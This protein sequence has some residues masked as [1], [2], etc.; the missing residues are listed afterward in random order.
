MP[1]FKRKTI[2]WIDFTEP[3]GKRVRRSSCTKVKAEAQR[4]HDELKARAW[5]VS[6]LGEKPRRTWDEA[7][8]KWLHET[9]DKKDHEGDKAKLRWLT[10]HL[11]GK[12]ID[13]IDR[14]VLMHL[15]ELKREET[16]ASTANRYTALLRA[17]LRR[18]HGRWQWLDKVPTMELFAEPAGRERW[19][20]AEQVERLLAELPDHQKLV[21]LFALAT[22]L[23]QGNILDLEWDRVDMRR[24]VCWIHGAQTKNRQALHVALNET[25]MG[26]LRQAAGEHPTR[27]FTYHGR[28]LS[29]ANTRAWRQALLR[30]GIENF[31]WHDLRHTW[32]SWMIQGGVPEFILQRMG[33]WKSAEMVKRYAHLAPATLTLHASTIDR[34]F[35][36]QRN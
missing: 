36:T 4:L 16:S 2:W 33:G 22:G 5:R 6:E 26:V 15:A 27:V 21:V 23:R 29:W 31:R 11:R 12:T 25:A 9:S 34:V 7:A 30:A 35:G 10:L 24:G 32:A 1:I 17:I 18:A 3:G 14:D 28:P 8:L 13:A 20:S 19:L